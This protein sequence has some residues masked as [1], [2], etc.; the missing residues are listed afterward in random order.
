MEQHTDSFGKTFRCLIADDSMFARKN[1]ARIVSGIGG[2]VIGEARNGTE[3]VDLYFKLA[4]VIVFLDI[5]LPELDGVVTLRRIIEK[6]SNAKV[7]IVSSIGHKEMVWKAI[8]LGAKHYITKPYN[9]SYAGMVI[10]SVIKQ[11]NGGQE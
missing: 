1:I 11:E 5:N 9:P 3:A 6:D 2:N 7:I 10:K 4:P 8:C